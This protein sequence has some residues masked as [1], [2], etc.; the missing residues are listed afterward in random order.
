MVS[1]SKLDD[2]EDS[3]ILIIADKNEFKK[4]TKLFKKRTGHN[5]EEF[6]KIIK[7]SENTIKLEPRF[8]SLDDVTVE[9]L[10]VIMS[11]ILK[12]VGNYRVSIDGLMMVLQKIKNGKTRMTKQLKYSF[13]LAGKLLENSLLLF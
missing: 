12:D 9:K 8:N 2:D 3:S 10:A 13:K 4:I 1:V 6:Y 5:I 7:L 11:N